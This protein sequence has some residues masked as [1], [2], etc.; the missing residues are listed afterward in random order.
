[1]RATIKRKV[2]DTDDAAQL[3]FRYFGEFGQPD[4][5]EERLFADQNGQHFI[6]GIGGP[7]SPYS[8]PIIRLL[9]ARQAV[10][11]KKENIAE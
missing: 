5:Y 7:E 2:Y 8:E 9:T 10:N 3:G 11:W 4:G 6:Y 1:M